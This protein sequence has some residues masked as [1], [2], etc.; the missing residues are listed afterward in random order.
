[1]AAW[2]RSRVDDRWCIGS[3]HDHRRH[4]PPVV[5]PDEIVADFDLQG[6][7][8]QLGDVVT[9][10]AEGVSKTLTISLLH[11]TGVDPQNDF[12]SGTAAPGTEIEVC[13]QYP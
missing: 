9:V 5:D 7:D 12:V 11:M 13:A 8:I 6:Y 4:G 1:M 10:T 2:R 3:L